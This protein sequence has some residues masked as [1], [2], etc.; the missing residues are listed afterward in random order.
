MAKE[1][2]VSVHDK[3]ARADNDVIYVCGNSDYVV[4]FS[5]DD[6]WTQYDTKTARFIYN[7]T[8]QD[9]VFTGNVCPVPKIFDANSIRVGLFAGDLK[10]STSAYIRARKGVLCESGTPDTPQDDVYAQI[11]EKL[12]DFVADVPQE[13]IDEAVAKYLKENPID[14]GVDE[15]QLAKA[16]E[17]AV[18]EAKD[19]G[20]FKGE[21]GHSPVR[22]VDYWTEDDKAEIKSYVD[23]AI[24]GG[25]W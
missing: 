4:V 7:G 12:N 1:I 8:H 6:E 24:L 5:L 3:I 10:T 18:Q 23:E 21:A 20:A 2:A 14:G 15:A 22:G 13:Q 11:M 9:K 19:S 25:A 16:V 17:A